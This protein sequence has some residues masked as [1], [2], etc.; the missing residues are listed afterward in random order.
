MMVSYAQNGEDVLLNRVFSGCR[1]GFYVDVG[2][3]DPIV[4]SVTKHFYQLGWRGINVEPHPEK[5][6][7]LCRDR[8]EDV[9]LN[10]GLCDREGV[11]TYHE[12]RP[13]GLSTFSAKEAARLSER[14]AKILER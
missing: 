12:C 11:L 13:T 14:G 8:P 6:G 7:R 4:H 2:A 10:V 9:S 5:Y 1:T 3:N